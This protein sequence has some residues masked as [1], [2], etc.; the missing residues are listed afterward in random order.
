MPSLHTHNDTTPERIG[1]VMLTHPARVI[2]RTP[3]T[4]KSDL[5]H[6]YATMAPYIV[7]HLKGRRVALLRC[8]AG[9]EED[10][11]FQKHL[12]G[13]VP[14]GVTRHDGH[15]QIQSAAGLL[16][17]VQLGVIEFHTWGSHAPR[18]DKP[19][20]ITMD[21]DPGPGVSWRRLVEGALLVHGLMTEVGL[22]P[23]LKTTGG[24]G[25]H[26][27][28]PIRATQ[29]WDTVRVFA[30]RLAERLADS[31]PERF[32]A[33]MAKAERRGRIFVDYLRNGD[34]ATAICAYSV[35]ARQQAPVAMP[36]AWDKL[37][38]H[39]DLRAARFTMRNA[40]DHV[41][42]HEDP[43]LDYAAHR[44]VLTRQMLERFG[45]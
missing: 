35:R 2:L 22:C 8:P 37:D 4:T 29:G 21:L 5:A 15:L 24:K 11:F 30:R 40:H 7:P 44:R 28:A 14:T 45:V 16:A 6:Y 38:F 41:Q 9:I 23:L 10:C 31:E 33:N 18:H 32:T 20:R 25:L 1:A 3:K 43:W 19:D 12:T 27:V 39:H 13:A 17:L 34:G 42:H 36:V 26:I